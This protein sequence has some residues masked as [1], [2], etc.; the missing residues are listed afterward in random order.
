MFEISYTN[1]MFNSLLLYLFDDLTLQIIRGLLIDPTPRHIRGL[2]RDYSA[3]P[4]GVSD[5]VR[6]LK[7]IGVVQERTDKNRRQLS[8]TV[9]DREKRVFLKLFA[10]YERHRVVRRA[11][12][13]NQQSNLLQQKLHDMDELYRFHR[14]AKKRCG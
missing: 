5:I 8:V 14:R 2:A 4:A 10:E 11:L 13:M 3:S 1:S 12:L 7:A 6:R 9:E